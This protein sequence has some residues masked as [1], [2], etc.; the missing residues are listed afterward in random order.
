[1]SSNMLD[2][3]AF[4]LLGIGLFACETA[5][6]EVPGPSDTELRGIDEEGG[7]IADA[8]VDGVGIGDRAESSAWA[9]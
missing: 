4:A 8:K 6:T 7:R 1:M 2:I 3:R 9:M 5:P